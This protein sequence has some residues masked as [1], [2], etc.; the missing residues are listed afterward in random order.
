MSFIHDD[1]L[2]QSDSARELYH[3]YAKNEPI[4]DYH[5]HLPP[6]DVA[7]NRRF[8]NLTEIWLEGDHYKW[9]A[10][11]SNG[12]SE[13]LCTG[14]AD[15]YDKFLA[16]CKTVPHTLRNPLYHW[17]HLELKRYFD[18]DNVLISEDSAREIWEAANEKLKSDEFSAHGILRRFSVK[19]V[20]TTDDP[21]DELSH[22]TAIRGLGL[23][24]K[25]VPTFR[26][27]KA[28]RVDQPEAFRAWVRALADVSEVNIGGFDT[29]LEALKSRH[30]FFHEM[31]GRLSDHG[32]E[33]CFFAATSK[34]E[35]E[36]VFDRAMSGQSA[37][38]AEKEAFGFYLMREFGRWNAQKGWTMQ[39]HVGAIRNNNTRLMQALGP[40]TGFDSIGDFPQ[41]EKMSH[42]LDSLDQSNELPKTIIYNINWSDNYAMGS[43]LGNFQDG[44]IPGKLQLGSGW[45]FLDQKEAMEAQMNALSNLGLL[46]RFVGMLTDSRSFM[47]YPRHEYFRR[48]LC[49][50]LGADM[51]N[52]ELPKDFDLV[53]NMVKKICF[54][55]AVEYF[56]IE[57]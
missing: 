43:M 8:A 54:G 53:G 35:A 23:D 26:P 11:R 22:H 40:D 9:R 25:V 31:G 41:V 39:L 7:S 21:T 15:P 52:G 45:W 55:N 19:V 18:I 2:L 49:N 10:M 44:A 56:G 28:L 4:F 16:W 33:R 20:G 51:E 46:S 47:S 48:V 57:L 34:E 6:E 5:C 3:D 38:D 17:S 36:G 32:L 12:V 14:D 42:F 37:S 29:F 1:F 24:T 13:T 30:D 27:D 50:L